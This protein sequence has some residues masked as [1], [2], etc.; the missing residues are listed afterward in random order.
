MTT[1]RAR[2]ALLAAALVAVAPWGCTEVPGPPSLSLEAID[3]P[4]GIA[5][6][7][8]PVVLRGA[9]FR[10][11]LET[12]LSGAA[13]AAA[14]VVVM[15]GGVAL[16]EVVL[17]S[18]TE[19]TA[20]V[21]ATLPVGLHDVSLAFPDGRTA[22]LTAAYEAE[23]PVALTLVPTPATLARQERG[24]VELT[25]ES[26]VDAELSL[27]LDQ[28]GASPPEAFALEMP[29]IPATLAARSVQTVTVT[30]DAIA[31]DTFPGTEGL[32]SARVRWTLGSVTGSSAAEAA[33]SLVPLVPATLSLQASLSE[34]SAVEGQDVA[35][36]VSLANSGEVGVDETTV[37]ITAAAGVVLLDGGNEVASL[38]IGPL[39]LGPA[40]SWS[41]GLPCR[42]KALG[43]HQITIDATGRDALTG[44]VV[45]ASTSTALEVRSPLPPAVEILVPAP[46]SG[47]TV[48]PGADLQVLVG[49][50]A[51]SGRTLGSIALAVAGPAT[52]LAPATVAES[53]RGTGASFTV[54]V[55]TGAG[56]G[57]VVTLTATAVDD[58]AQVGSSTPSDVTV[59]QSSTLVRVTCDP[60]TLVLPAGTNG[61][62]HL[63]AL[64]SDG[65]T[66]D[67]CST[68]SWTTSAASVAA[69]SGGIVVP[70]GAGSATLTG[71]FS[72]QSG[73]CD[74]I[75]F[76][77]NRYNVPARLALGVTG[78]AQVRHFAVGFPEPTDLT[79]DPGTTWTASDPGVATVTGGVV[80]GAASGFARVQACNAGA[81]ATTEV[82]V[83]ADLELPGTLSAGPIGMSGAQHFESLLIRA[84]TVVEVVDAPLEISVAES[85]ILESGAVI[86]ANGGDASG[87]S[88]SG[89][90]LPLRAEGGAGAPGGGG[91]G[92]G[93]GGNASN[94]CGSGNDN[95]GG[96][97]DPA[98][99][100]ACKGGSCGGGSGGG[101]GGGGG[102][103]PSVAGQAGDAGGG[104][105][106]GA[107]GGRG[108][109]N[110]SG[111]WAGAAGA[112][113]GQTPLG[114]G[115]G[116]G[117]GDGSTGANG[118]GGGGGGG[119]GVI[120]L[121][122]IGAV[123]IR[124]DGTISARGGRGGSLRAAA[125][126]GP[127][128][129]AAGGLI[130][131]T[132]PAGTVGGTGRLLA[133]GGAGGDWGGSAGPCGGGGG[134]GGGRVLVSAP[135]AGPFILVTAPGGRSGAP[136]T[137]GQAG[138]AGAL[139]LV[140][141]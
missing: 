31:P 4:R 75:V 29:V 18:E 25:L 108:G 50:L 96:S 28:A 20:T 45:T 92:A 106:H 61:E 8:T 76:D 119:G 126:S 37:T 137:G 104:G 57:A 117:G 43:T 113:S 134:G 131:I 123:T 98:G 83:G 118:S 15:V 82:V 115:S 53:Q 130:E 67:V 87:V 27:E 74:V 94:L 138:E 100:N 129:G 93:S 122:G 124:I 51:D 66:Q 121:A 44:A 54:H 95:C 11:W 49:G 81:C 2:A 139:G 36:L 114:G 116:G 48:A 71:V 16:E 105:G 39:T 63:E 84:G 69:I 10:Y 141:R 125:T 79:S 86:R 101:P 19:L 38:V 103:P 111:Q 5:G 88:M 21:P 91:G 99:Q 78:F 80:T 32:V 12:S 56:D 30:L 34:Q 13:P 60:A 107:A 89:P 55:N 17:Q 22:A 140:Q 102:S 73:S 26:L 70:V 97:G 64:W 65:T 7:R 128:G 72:G 40:V 58:N 23:P 33:V 120:R 112:T 68:A 6:L 135:V 62:L 24:L 136:C 46:G 14:D 85:F 9:S 1:R 59:Q 42:A 77:A 47:L 90:E 52:V 109:S 41:Q 110:V 35:L 133:A 3:P 127:G 132:A